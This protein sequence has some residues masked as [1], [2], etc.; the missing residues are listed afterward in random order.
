MRIATLVVICLSALAT[1]V[2]E[3]S[4]TANQPITH[5]SI[6]GVKLGQQEKTYERL[7][8]EPFQTEPAPGGGPYTRVVFER[9]KVAVYFFNGFDSGIEIVTW[10]KTDRST[11]GIGPCSPIR[12]L[13]AAY[14]T[15][16]RPAPANTI[17]GAAYVYHAGNTLFAANGKPPHPSKQITAVAIYAP[18]LFAN[19][20]PAAYAG[21]FIL[22][23]PNC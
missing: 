7:L 5:T 10:N 12:A 14:G 2:V 8:G 21:F 1:A 13:K 3:A 6:A 22:N 23:T 18:A 9:R 15:K 19:S 16:V 20:R 4:A 17:N 11:T